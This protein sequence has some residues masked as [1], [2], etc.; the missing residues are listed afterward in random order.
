MILILLVAAAL[1]AITGDLADCAVTLLVI[2]VNT[3]VGVLQERRA[4]GAVT[5]LRSLATPYAIVVRDGTAQRR[6]CCTAA[7]SSCTEPVAPRSSRRARG[8]RSAGS[9]RCSKRQRRQAGG[10][11]GGQA[12]R[13]GG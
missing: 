5:A 7:R 9:R 11:V 4:V 10:A 3:T 1:T 12:S 2:T 13:P 8:Q 6:R